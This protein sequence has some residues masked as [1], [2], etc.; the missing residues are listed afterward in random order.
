[1]DQSTTVPSKYHSA[2]DRRN[3]IELSFQETAKSS[4]SMK[5]HRSPVLSLTSVPKK[6]QVSLV[7]ISNSMLPF[8]HSYVLLIERP[9]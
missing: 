8:V 6:S 5:L 2:L 9:N 7:Q 4:R 1:M 3:C